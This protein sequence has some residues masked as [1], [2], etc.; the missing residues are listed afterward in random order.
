MKNNNKMLTK[1]NTPTK[2]P[3]CILVLRLKDNQL[4]AQLDIMQETIQDATND[5]SLSTIDQN[6]LCGLL[7]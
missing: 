6:V 5:L 3:S 4:Q 1:I 2:L 7:G